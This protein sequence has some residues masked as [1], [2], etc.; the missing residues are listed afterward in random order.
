LLLVAL[1]AGLLAGLVSWALHEI[2]TTPIILKAETYE[3][4]A[5]PASGD[6]T[7][8]GHGADGWPRSL[9]TLG[10]DLVIGIGYGALLVAGF[11][12]F[13]GRVDW[14]K[15]L[16]WGL[17]GFLAFALAP[18]IG[19]PPELPGAAAAP[20]LAR[21]AWWL[22][23]A[24]STL[25]GL[26]AI[27]LV[28]KRIAI[29]VGVALIVLPHLMGAPKPEAAGG[30]APAELEQAFVLAAL[31]ISLAFWLVLGGVGGLLYP[32]LTERTR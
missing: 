32:R 22:L 23:T 9:A 26:G 18:S 3:Q 12:F 7:A 31:G 19:L 10:A 17:G 8:H 14:R 27:F 16:L 30:L 25:L 29:P 5:A 28:R 21:Q 11:T 1:A 4:G 15:G 6:G 20:L 2:G 24:A 13:G